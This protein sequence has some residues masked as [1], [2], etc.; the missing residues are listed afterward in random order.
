MRT[1]LARV[2]IWSGRMSNFIHRIIM[3]VLLISTLAI[4]WN[5]LGGS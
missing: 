4:A 1:G 3:L 2:L 5:L